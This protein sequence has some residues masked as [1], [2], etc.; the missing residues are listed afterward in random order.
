[1]SNNVLDSVEGIVLGISIPNSEDEQEKSRYQAQ[2]ELVKEYDMPHR[3]D[4]DKGEFGV[5]FLGPF[6]LHH[7][8]PSS[9]DHGE[10]KQQDDSSEGGV[11]PD[12]LYRALSIIGLE[13]VE[14]GPMVSIDEME[15]LKEVLTKKLNGFGTSSNDNSRRSSDTCSAADQLVRAESVEAYKDGQRQLLQLALAELDSLIMHLGCDDDRFAPS[16]PSTMPIQIRLY[17]P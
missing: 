15:I 13:N 6:S 3:I 8:L 9:K 10:D 12:E 2:V 16:W 11:I 7:K 14:E 17:L 5:L 4:K 1:M